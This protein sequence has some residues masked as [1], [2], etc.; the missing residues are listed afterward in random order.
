M[1]NVSM[2]VVARDPQ[3]GQ[4]RIYAYKKGDDPDQLGMEVNPQGQACPIV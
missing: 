1:V 2:Y 4:D 3:T